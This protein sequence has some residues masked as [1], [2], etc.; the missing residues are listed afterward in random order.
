MNM[1]ET[2]NCDRN[3]IRV[4]ALTNL[5][6]ALGYDVK[7]LMEITIER[8]ESEQGD[9][10][11]VIDHLVMLTNE[12]YTMLPFD[13]TLA[14]ELFPTSEEAE[15]VLREITVM[16]SEKAADFEKL[17]FSFKRDLSVRY[18]EAFEYLYYH[19]AGQ[20]EIDMTPM[21]THLTE[22]RIRRNDA[23]RRFFAITEGQN[24]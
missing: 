1:A 9:K 11:D 19:A 3:G 21:G 14:A 6:N 16:L 13:E 24:G 4:I 2:V 15:H 7:A 5:D 10:T 12:Y 23:L 22:L 18:A 17:Y 8:F 20:S